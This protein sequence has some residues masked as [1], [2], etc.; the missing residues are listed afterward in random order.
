MAV[1][2]RLRF[3]IL[4]RD[5]HTCQL[6]GGSAPEVRLTV[7][8]VIPVTLGGPDAAENL[9]AAC[10]DCNAGKSSVP[11]DA[12]MV[13]TVNEAA[14]RY[15]AAIMATSEV[16]THEVEELQAERD[17]FEGSWLAWTNPYGDTYPMPGNWEATVDR[18]MSLGMTQTL[19]AECVRI[20]MSKQG[21]TPDVKFRYFCGVAWG[22]VREMQDTAMQIAD[23]L[24]A[25]D[26]EAAGAP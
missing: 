1:S 25:Q 18:F 14:K 4:R 2:K 5:N 17:T 16:F 20:A 24:E 23:Q 12:P 8:H 13:A 26:R 21:L 3:E 10:V 6:C 9:Q 19:L 15:R 22:K 7:D 11:A